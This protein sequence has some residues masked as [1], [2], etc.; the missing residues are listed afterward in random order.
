MVRNP[1]EQKGGRRAELQTRAR[2]AVLVAPLQHRA[3]ARQRVRLQTGCLFFFSFLTALW[4]GV[5]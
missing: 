5:A 2:H 4:H 3:T 1:I